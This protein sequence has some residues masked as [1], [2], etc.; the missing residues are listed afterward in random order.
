MSEIKREDWRYKAENAEK[1][2]F[3][4][5][6]SISVMHKEM[7]F[8]GVNFYGVKKHKM[9]AYCMCNMCH[10]KGKPVIYIGYSNRVEVDADH[11]PI[12]SCGEEAIKTWNTRKP[13]E[14]IV[15]RLEEEVEY[16]NKKANEAKEDV[17][18]EKI[19][20][21]TVRISM[22]NCYKHA[23]EIVKGANDE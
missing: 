4:G 20:E 12:Y 22:R 8:L 1:C 18:E 9:Q 10:A 21:S 14:R 23:I 3:C 16:Q 17:F 7:R 19:S 11:L 15:E 5:S 6:G 13:M 2:P